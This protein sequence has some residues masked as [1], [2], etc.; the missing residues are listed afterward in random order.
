MPNLSPD[1]AIYS[2]PSFLRFHPAAADSK[3]ARDRVVSLTTSRHG[4]R[5]SD[6]GPLAQLRSMA[7]SLNA[8][9][10]SST[11]T[12]FLPRRI[13]L[14]NGAFR[15]SSCN[16]V[17]TRLRARVHQVHGLWPSRTLPRLSLSS[18]PSFNARACCKPHGLRAP[19][20]HPCDFAPARDMCFLRVH[21]CHK[22]LRRSQPLISSRPMHWACIIRSEESP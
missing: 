18:A 20:L 4:L 2:S 21:A 10:G 19:P 13:H 17:P 15:G 5:G 8:A 3:R 1:L 11:K 7:S 6:S 12:S 22:P 9:N 16:P 14:R